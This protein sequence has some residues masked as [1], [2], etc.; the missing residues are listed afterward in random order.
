MEVD[1]TEAA[2]QTPSDAVNL[3]EKVCLDIVL[4]MFL[5][6]LLRLH[7]RIQME[8]RNHSEEYREEKERIVEGLVHPSPNVCILYD[9]R[10]QSL[11][12]REKK[13]LPNQP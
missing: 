10:M 5:S 4:V 13:R 8:M 6:F 3:Q 9:N 12:K 7:G 2:K 1:E 11:Q